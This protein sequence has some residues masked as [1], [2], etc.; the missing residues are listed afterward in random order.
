MSI[1]TLLKLQNTSLASTMSW[2]DYRSLE[3]FGTGLASPSLVTK[4]PR[5]LVNDCVDQEPMEAPERSRADFAATRN[6]TCF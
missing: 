3:T 5:K 4:D 2:Q 1:R 6:E